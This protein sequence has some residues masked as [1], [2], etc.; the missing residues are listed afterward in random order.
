LRCGPVTR[1]P[2]RRWL[3]WSASSAS[4]PPQMRPVLQDS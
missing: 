3:C 1:S 2:S 4:F